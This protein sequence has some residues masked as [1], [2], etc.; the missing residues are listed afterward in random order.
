MRCCIMP[1]QWRVCLTWNVVITTVMI[2]LSHSGWPGW[3]QQIN[4]SHLGAFRTLALY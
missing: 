4:E 3:R 2:E 1:E